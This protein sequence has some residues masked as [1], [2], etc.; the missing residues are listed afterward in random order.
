[1]DPAVPKIPFLRNRIFHT[2]ERAA[3]GLPKHV[4]QLKEFADIRK[5]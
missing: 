3:I 1:V 2:K 4:A 5:L